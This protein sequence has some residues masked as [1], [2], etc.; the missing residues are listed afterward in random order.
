MKG[1]M[2]S[3]REVEEVARA[4]TLGCGTYGSEAGFC[5]ILAIGILCVCVCLCVCCANCVLSLSVILYDDDVL[6]KAYSGWNSLW[7]SKNSK[8]F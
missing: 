7:S 6:Q 3:G 5:I 1:D 2:R 4:W 8:K